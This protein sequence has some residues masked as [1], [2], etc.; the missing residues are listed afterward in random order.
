MR[1]VTWNV[2]RRSSR[3][4]EQAAALA[5][6]EPDVIALQEVTDRTLPMWRAVLERIGLPHVTASLDRADP[7]R[8][9]VDRRRT[10]VLVSSRAQLADASTLSVPWPETATAAVASFA[11]TAA[12]EVHT[13]HVPNAANGWIKVQ[14]LQAIRS[15]LAAAPAG[16]RVLC[17]DLNIP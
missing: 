17:G 5:S 9:P 11:S 6:R 7:A 4:A 16:P 1:I 8:V 3:L 10:G 12:V 14:T 15:G 2:A 13:V